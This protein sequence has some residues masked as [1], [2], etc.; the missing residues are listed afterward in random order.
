MGRNRNRRRI[1][2]ERSSGLGG[3]AILGR[4]WVRTGRSLRSTAGVTFDLLVLRMCQNGRLILWNHV[5]WRRL[6]ARQVLRG[7]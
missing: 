7:Q 2:R 6:R 3:C 4:W 1:K 5:E